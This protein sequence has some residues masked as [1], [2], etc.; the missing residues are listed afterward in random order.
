[1]F[2]KTEEVSDKVSSLVETLSE[3]QSDIDEG[4]YDTLN[5]YDLKWDAKAVWDVI[6]NN[7]KLSNNEQLFSQEEIDYFYQNIN[8]DKAI[9]FALIV[10]YL[11]SVDVLQIL[12]QT[13]SDDELSLFENEPQV[14]LYVQAGMPG[15]CLAYLGAIERSTLSIQSKLSAMSQVILSI[16]EYKEQ[17]GTLS[18]LAIQI[19]VEHWLDMFEQLDTNLKSNFSSSKEK[20][21]TLAKNCL[22]IIEANKKLTVLEIYTQKTLENLNPFSDKFTLKC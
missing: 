2:F 4:N 15:I 12:K 1:M 6:N 3:Y 18:D 14:M 10:Q 7:L 21:K 22:N 11:T 19:S 13:K 20:Y 5:Y 9:P 8:I 17:F 16:A